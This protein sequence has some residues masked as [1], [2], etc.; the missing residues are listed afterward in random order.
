MPAVDPISE[1]AFDMQF[2]FFKS[3]CCD[4]ILE[5]LTKDNFMPTSDIIGKR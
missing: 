4:I 1:K 3:K 5:I 2:N